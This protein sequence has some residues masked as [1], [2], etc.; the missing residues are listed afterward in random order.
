[1]SSLVN[2]ASTRPRSAAS[3]CCCTLPSAA[4]SSAALSDAVAIGVDRLEVGIEALEQRCAVLRRLRRSG[5][6]AWPARLRGGGATAVASAGAATPSARMAA[7][8]WKRMNTLA[9]PLNRHWSLKITAHLAIRAG[10]VDWPHCRSA[11]LAAN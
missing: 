10:A 8:E 11:Y 7:I 6:P 1:M 2:S 3:R 9:F 4:A 5:A